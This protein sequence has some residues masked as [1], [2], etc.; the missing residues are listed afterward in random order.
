MDLVDLIF[1]KR[2]IGQE[3]LTW[4]WYKS[5]E[6]GGS[7]YVPGKGDIQVIFERHML[8]EY[9]E[10]ES[11][12]SLICRGLQT[13]LQEARTGLQM[14]KKVEQA[15]IRLGYGDYEWS[16]SLRAGLLEFRNMRTPKTMTSAEETDDQLGAEGKI[17][18]KIGLV[19]EAVR[20]VHDLFRMFLRVRVG[21]EWEDKELAKVRDWVHK[22]PLP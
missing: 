11:N 10:G 9:G 19:E 2:F 15:R 3:F 16:F 7:V 4:L 13:E 5:E 22:R 8:L 20:T 21:P 6:R 14:G 1:E 12:E 17:L 18:E